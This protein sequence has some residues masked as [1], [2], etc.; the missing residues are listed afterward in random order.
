MGFK[1]NP[2]IYSGL[3][4]TGTSTGPGPG[5]VDINTGTTGQLDAARIGAGTVSNSEFSYLD[6]VI[7]E[8]SFSG[9]QNASNANVTGFIIPTASIRT[10]K[11]LVSVTVD[12]T[13]DLYEQIEIIGI[14]RGGTWSLFFVQFGDNSGVTFTITAAG[15]IQYSSTSY[16]GFVSLQIN[17]RSISLKI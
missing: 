14:N 5:T 8:T 11:A 16:S 15:Q 17:F 7:P 4:K 2:L 1:F 9:T 3:V 12:A 13:S 10:F 6:G